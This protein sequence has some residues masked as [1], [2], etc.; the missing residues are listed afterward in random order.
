MMITLIKRKSKSHFLLIVILLF[1]SSSF[2]QE[3]EKISPYNT[4]QYFKNTDNQ[5]SLQTTLTYSKNRMEIPVPGMEISFFTNSTKKELLAKVVTDDNG[6]ARVLLKDVSKLPADKENLWQF[7]SEYNGNDT[8]EASTTELSVKDTELEMSL[9]VVDSIRT[10]TLTAT[11]IQKGQRI[12][13]SGEVVMIYVPRMFSLLPVAE[14][15]LDEN[16]TATVEFPSDLP[17]DEEGNLKIIA[18][19]EENPTYGNVEKTT[20]QSWGIPTSYSVPTTHRALWTKTPPMWMIVTL[21]I[22]LAGVWGHYL[23][24]V[25]SLILIKIDAKRKKVI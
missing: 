3:A 2:S 4:L 18:R 10:I 17:G 5:S 7:V 24:A 20:I 1:S 25:I 23:F 12:P 6:I 22:L 21:S 9:S 15:T 14:A 11:T 19:I 16:G 13:V 8:I